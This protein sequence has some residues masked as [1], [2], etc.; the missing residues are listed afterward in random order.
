[1][2]KLGVTCGGLPQGDYKTHL[3][4]S[5]DQVDLRSEERQNVTSG[6][7]TLPVFV[8]QGVHLWSP[9]GDHSG[10][11]TGGRRRAGRQKESVMKHYIYF[12]LAPHPKWVVLS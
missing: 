7:L 5:I 12:D 10:D 11:A 9:R 6:L 2:T 4:R 8:P 1:M 3:S